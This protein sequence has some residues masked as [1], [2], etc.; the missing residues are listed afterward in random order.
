MLGLAHGVH[1]IG[2]SVAISVHTTD[3]NMPDVDDYIQRLEAAIA[4]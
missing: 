2:D 3:T 1:R 4:R